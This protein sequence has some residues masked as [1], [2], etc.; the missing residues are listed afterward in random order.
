MCEITIAT[1]VTQNILRRFTADFP[2]SLDRVPEKLK[3]EIICG[4]VR[5]ITLNLILQ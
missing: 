5:L 4:S 2:R 1:Q 3:T